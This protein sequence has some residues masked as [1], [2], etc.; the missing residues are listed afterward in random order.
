MN[1]KLLF[2]LTIIFVLSFGIFALAN[3]DYRVNLDPIGDQ[4]YS[5][6]P[7]TYDVTGTVT[8]DKNAEINWIKLYVTGP[9]DDA[10]VYKDSYYL[11]DDKKIGEDG[12]D[13]SI[14]WVIK[15]EGS[16]KVKVVAEIA[17]DDGIISRQDIEY[18]IEITLTSE[19]D[20][21]QATESNPAAPAVA[22]KILKELGIKH[23]YGGGNYISDV[24]REMAPGTEFQ[25]VAKTSEDYENEI[26][27]YLENH[28]AWDE[29]AGIQNNKPGKGNGN[30]YG[31][32]KEKK[33]NA[34]ENG[35]KKN[36]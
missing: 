8:G 34:A 19:G 25:G 7:Q 24:A 12:R 15:K 22:N 3:Q 32:N 18:D 2:V 20:Q 6:L 23:N 11:G 30:A 5:S 28:E 36:K 10:F 29:D 27:A 14:P 9:N 17:E 1:K 21:E 13:F 31:L 35:N 33:N 4:E 16:Y 26:K